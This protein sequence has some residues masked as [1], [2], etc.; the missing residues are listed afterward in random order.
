MAEPSFN[1]GRQVQVLARLWRT[2]L[3]RRLK[4][5]GLSQARLVLLIHV[6]EHGGGMTQFEL[7]D[8]AGVKGPTLVR[9]I[10]QLEADG[11]VVRRDHE[12]DRRSKTVHLTDEGRERMSEAIEIADALRADLQADVGDGDLERT[13]AV[14]ARMTRRIEEIGRAATE[15]REGDVEA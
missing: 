7:A 5:H 11:L 10:D 13:R 4:A 1:I 15:E 9:Q 12:T 2:E 8:Q 14:L 3:D 6:F